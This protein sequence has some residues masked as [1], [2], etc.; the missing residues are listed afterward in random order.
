MKQQSTL[1]DPW[2]NDAG[3]Q[4][5]SGLEQYY[6]YWAA[7]YS[8]WLLPRPN[9]SCAPQASNFL[10]WGL[11][12][13]WPPTGTLLSFHHS[14]FTPCRRIKKKQNR[15]TSLSVWFRTLSTV[16]QI[17]GPC[18]CESVCTCV[19]S[20]GQI[21]MITVTSSKA[22]KVNH[23]C[24][25]M[26]MIPAFLF[27]FKRVFTYSVKCTWGIMHHFIISSWALCTVSTSG[28]YAARYG[29]MDV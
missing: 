23:N 14:L 9:N 7:M 18:V 12:R 5:P 3:D 20:W 28:E 13:Y 8:I 22:P 19:S 21:T 10:S 2:R 6:C 25:N 15:H 4:Q 26:Q 11:C 17:R 27:D 1:K 16:S 24:V 29:S